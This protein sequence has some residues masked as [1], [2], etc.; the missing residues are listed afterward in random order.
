MKD[1]VVS[2]DQWIAARKELLVK[3]K[4]LSARRDELTRMRQQLPWHKVDTKYEFDASDGKQQLSD[5][6][7]RPSHQTARE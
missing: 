4:E 1:K 5:L 2:E 3:E 6:F 7:A